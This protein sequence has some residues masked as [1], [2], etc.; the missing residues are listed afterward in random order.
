MLR[1][2]ADAAAFHTAQPINNDVMDP[3][4]DPFANSDR[5]I[6]HTALPVM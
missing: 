3:V 4:K 6:Y 5:T 1:R 2:V